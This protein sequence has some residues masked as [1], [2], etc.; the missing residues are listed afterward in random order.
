MAEVGLHEVS[1]KGPGH[2][3]TT[4]HQLGANPRS[5][6]A[7]T[8][9]QALALISLVPSF[10]LAKDFIYTSK[11]YIL[12]ILPF[13]SD[14]LVPLLLRIATFQT[15]L[16]AATVCEFVHGGP[17]RNARVRRPFLRRCGE[18]T[19]HITCVNKSLV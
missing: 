14:P 15:N 3:S 9:R 11:V 12:S 2:S 17:A 10:G 4:W 13:E 16:A 19:H 7:C 6:W 8:R 1:P 18:R 5:S